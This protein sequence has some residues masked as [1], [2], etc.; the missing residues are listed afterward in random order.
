MC[1][2]SKSTGML[3]VWPTT[4]M[5]PL[6][7]GRT[8]GSRATVVTASSVSMSA[9]IASEPAYCH[10]GPALGKRRGVQHPARTETCD[11]ATATSDLLR[12]RSGS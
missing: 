10:A 6:R 2:R 7:N 4:S 12:G 9:T 11:S 5:R 3:A 8:W 1:R